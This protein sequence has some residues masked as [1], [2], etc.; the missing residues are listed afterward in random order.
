MAINNAIGFSTIGTDSGSAVISSTTPNFS[1]VGGG[2]A[3][4]SAS[5]STITI[6]AGTDEIFQQVRATSTTAVSSTSTLASTGTTPTTSNTTSLISATITPNN[7]NNVLI[8][9][10]SAPISTDTDCVAQ[11]CLFEGSTFRTGYPI[12]VNGSAGNERNAF[13]TFRYYR[14]AGTTS[15][16]T[17]SVRGAVSGGGATLR[18]LQN[19]AGTAFYNGAGNSAITF[20]ITEIAV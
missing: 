19:G 4:T 8:F 2:S 10:F 13:M 17:F 11:F 18:L 9:D 3:S 20:I 5:G 7:A 14:V 6:S 15:S 12:W 16:T 1:I